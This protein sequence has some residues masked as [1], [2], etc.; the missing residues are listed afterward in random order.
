MRATFQDMAC[1]TR[2]VLSY[3]STKTSICCC[4]RNIKLRSVNSN[5]NCK[6][7]ILE[8][9]KKKNYSLEDRGLFHCI[10]N[11]VEGYTKFESDLDFI[12]RY[13]FKTTYLLSGNQ[14]QGLTH[15]R[16]CSTPA[17]CSPRPLIEC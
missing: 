16:Q 12:T 11:S 13:F 7:K 2:C 10:A 5:I 8:S 3:F 14:T 15:A 9:L 4:I 6:V 17:T 1:K